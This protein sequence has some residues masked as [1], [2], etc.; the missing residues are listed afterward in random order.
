MDTEPAACDVAPDVDDRELVEL[1]VRFAHSFLRFLDGSGSDGLSY[2][3]LCLLEVLHCQGPAKMKTLADGLGLSARN[4]TAMADSLECEGLVRRVAHPTDRRA[5]L[6]E[7]TCEGQAAA[8]ES[9]APR[10]AEISRVF[11][12]LSPAAREGLRSALTTL[13][14]ATAANRCPSVRAD[15]IELAGHE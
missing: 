8:E 1:S 14:E 13:V 15:Q 10:L 6:L 3:R 9:L 7:L 4:L 12:E 2:P 5:T 11:G